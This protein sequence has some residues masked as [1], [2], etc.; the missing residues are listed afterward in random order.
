VAREFRNNTDVHPVARIGARPEILDK[1]LLA[2]EI[3]ANL[4]C[5]LICDFGVERL[6]D[7]APVNL[8]GY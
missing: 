2:I 7:I 1:E 3:R 5:Q 4:R 8:I 6:V